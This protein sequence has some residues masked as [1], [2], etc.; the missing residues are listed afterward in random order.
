VRITVYINTQNQYKLKNLFT[1]LIL[2]FSFAAMSQPSERDRRVILIRNNHTFEFSRVTRK[3]WISVRTISGA[4]LSGQVRTVKGDTIF[5]QDTLLRVSDIDSLFFQR[6]PSGFGQFHYDDLKTAYIAGSPDWKIFIPPDSVYYNPGTFHIYYTRLVHH[7]TQ[8]RHE[9]R[10][11]LLYRNFMKVNIAKMLHMEVAFSYERL[12]TENF[13][14]ETELS[15]IFGVPSADAYYM[16]NYPL[17]NYNGFSITTYPKLYVINSRTYLGLVFMYRYLT[18]NGIRTDWPDKGDNGDLQDQYRNDYGI[19]FRIG[20]M[21]CY[22]KFVVDYYVGGGVKYIMLHQ[23]VYGSYLY[24]DSGQMH[25][26]NEDHSANVSDRRLIGPVI[27]VGIKLGLA[28]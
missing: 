27:N 18:V 19:S 24:H 6:G 10:F 23:L 2:A 25:W 9:T 20:F 14:W 11:P 13:T 22:G 21:K 15:A 8:E 28:F 7:A 16:N 1:L 3:T 5:F 4:K 12:I 17:Y 26:F